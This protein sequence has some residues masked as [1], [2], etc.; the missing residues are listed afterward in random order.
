MG[1]G[2]GNS[3]TD[4]NN[5]TYIAA[6]PKDI[7]I[8]YALAK[9]LIDR[10]EDVSAIPYENVLNW[11]LDK[12][13][14]NIAMYKCIVADG[15]KVGYFHLDSYGVEAELDDLYIL[16]NYR[17]RGIGTTVIKYCMQLAKKPIFLYVFCKNTGAIRLYERMGFVKRRQK[18][19][20]PTCARMRY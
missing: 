17:G 18:N 3:V 14:E 19:S 15:I 7:P 10:Y 2:S 13:T 4:L 8:I 6:E 20:A 9:D 5:L 11:T 12:I 16:P 1:R